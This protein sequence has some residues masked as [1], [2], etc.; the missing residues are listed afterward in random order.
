MFSS[1]SSEVTFELVWIVTVIISG[2][3]ASSGRMQ[4]IFPVG[5][6]ISVFLVFSTL[7]FFVGT[8]FYDTNGE[9]GRLRNSI[10][11]KSFNLR[12]TVERTIFRFN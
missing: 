3:C 7:A 9:L 11:Y 6:V 10:V 8:F 2:I 5:V 1:I 4:Q 12:L